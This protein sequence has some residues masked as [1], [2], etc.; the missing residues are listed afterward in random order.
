MGIDHLFGW[1]EKR[2]A[3]RQKRGRRQALVTFAVVLGVLLFVLLSVQVSS[4]QVPQ[5][6][7]YNRAYDLGAAGHIDDL[8]LIDGKRHLVIQQSGE[9]RIIEVSTTGFTV[10]ARITNPLS[11]DWGHML[12]VVPDVNGDGV[13]DIATYGHDSQITGENVFYMLSGNHPPGSVVDGNSAAIYTIPFG[14]VMPRYASAKPGSNE[15]LLTEFPDTARRRNA[16]T[17]KILHTVTGPS[18]ANGGIWVGDFDGDSVP[19]YLTGG[20]PLAE[21]SPSTLSPGLI[22]PTA[23]PPV[24]LS[25][26]FRTL[27]LLAWDTQRITTILRQP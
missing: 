11:G 3:K 20:S 19:D 7:S 22:R 27:P 14:Q 10:R 23:Q 21:P 12:T 13:N 9:I 16:A 26:P 4:A 5:V 24:G 8:G 2:L 25:S 1:C 6:I 15:I 18:I 17:G